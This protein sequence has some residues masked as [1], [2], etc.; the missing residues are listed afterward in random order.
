MVTIY[1]TSTCPTCQVAKGFMKQNNI[2]YVEKNVEETRYFEEM[3][4]RTSEMA[5]PQIDLNGRMVVGFNPTALQQ[6]VASIAKDDFDDFDLGVAYSH[7]EAE[8]CVD[9]EG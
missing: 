4:A 5:V 8:A 7:S 9:C 3:V 1:T 6:Y 2:D